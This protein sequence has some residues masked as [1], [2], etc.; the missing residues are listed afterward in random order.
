MQDWEVRYLHE[1]A[2]RDSQCVSRGIDIPEDPRYGVIQIP[3][4]LFIRFN[5]EQFWKLFEDHGH[6]TIEFAKCKC[7]TT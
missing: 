4:N 5:G 6:T 7:H 3:D 2:V 1:K